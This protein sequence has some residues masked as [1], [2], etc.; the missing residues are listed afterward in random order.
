MVSDMKRL[1]IFNFQF[2]ILFLIGLLTA[3]ALYAEQFP[4]VVEAEEMATV[5]A[6]R[7]GGV[8]THLNVSVGDRVAKGDVLGVVFH[9]DMSL[10]KRELEAKKRYL[11]TQ[12]ENLTRL[13]EKGMSTDIELAK[14]KTDLT[15]SR[16]GMQLADMQIGKS[17]IKAPFSGVIVTTHIRVHEWVSGG[18][19]VDMYNPEALRIVAGIPSEIAVTFKPGREDILFFPD[20]GQEV[21]ATFKVLSPQVDVRS[22][23]IKVYWTVSKG[24]LKKA[25]LLPGMKGVLK[26]GGDEE[27]GLLQDPLGTD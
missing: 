20:I 26:L 14:A 4:V 24:E 13:N 3:S 9:K 1:S 10:K 2:S 15:V 25:R 11:E 23:T 19:L 16:I 22:G 7:G 21:K 6:Q 5:P 27:D 8:L 12:L 18:P 17:F